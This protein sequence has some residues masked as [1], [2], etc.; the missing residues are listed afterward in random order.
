MNELRDFFT[1]LT[2]TIGSLFNLVI[3]LLVAG[4]IALFI[5]ITGT[6]IT[7]NVLLGFAIAL[8]SFAILLVILPKH[9]NK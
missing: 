3:L 8:L 2:K 5:F 1:S 4:I 7:H 9:L 6:I